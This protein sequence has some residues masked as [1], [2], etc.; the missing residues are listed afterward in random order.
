MEPTWTEG[1]DGA[2]LSLEIDGVDGEKRDAR[3]VAAFAGRVRVLADGD[4][5]P[6]ARGASLRDVGLVVAG[7]CLG[8]LLADLVL[9]AAF[10]LGLQPSPWLGV[11]T[12]GVGALLPVGTVLA[13]QARPLAAR[14]GPVVDRFTLALDASGLSVR[15][16]KRDEL[17][18]AFEHLHAL[19]GG[20]RLVAVLADGTRLEL[21]CD[22]GDR[23]R[24]D[25][26]AAR[27][28]DM[29]GRLRAR[30]GG[31]R[32]VRVATTRPEERAEAPSN[33]APLTPRRAAR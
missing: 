11:V 24:H 19:E 33:D 3:D 20:R 27:F 25:E 18:F 10:A 12:F 1:E 17:R 30:A 21:P 6:G 15:G 4:A 8:A 32:G 9:S 5:P 14:S 13:L 2:S 31:Y 23:A 22:L 26:I 16:R 7:L 28:T 29:L